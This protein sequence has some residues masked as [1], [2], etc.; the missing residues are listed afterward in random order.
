MKVDLLPC[1]LVEA[2]STWEFCGSFHGIT[3]KF[4]FSVEVEASI[5]TVNCGFH[6]YIAVETSVS[7][8]MRE[9]CLH[10]KPLFQPNDISTPS[11]RADSSS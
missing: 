2:G 11:V 9:C 3:W 8:C 7:F 5:A 6:E 4:P 1:E 10:I